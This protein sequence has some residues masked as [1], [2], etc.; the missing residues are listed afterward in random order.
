[1]SSHKKILHNYHGKILALYIV[2]ESTGLFTDRKKQKGTSPRVK[3]SPH[4]GL[5]QGRCEN[6]RHRSERHEYDAAK[7]SIVSNASCT[8]NCL[9]PLSH[10]LL[11]EGIGIETGLMRTIHSYTATQKTVDGPSKKDWRG[12]RAGGNQHY[13]SSTGAAKAVGE[14]FL[15]T[16]R[17]ADR[18][19]IPHTDGRR[20]V[21]DLRSVRSRIHR[22]RKLNR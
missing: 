19:V 21:I 6:P 9:A 4:F 7:H 3:E 1:V 15:A 18:H 16:E 12:G 22:F 8:T 2:I 5:S 13:S 17:E 11:K 20:S 10:V 14:F